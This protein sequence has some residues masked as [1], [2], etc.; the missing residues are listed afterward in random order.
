MTTQA[1]AKAILRHREEMG[2]EERFTPHDL[3]RTLRTRLAE[4]GIDDVI[5]ERIL[6]HKLQGIMAIYNRHG[7]DNEKRHALEKW[8]NKLKQIIGIKESEIGKI[9]EMRK[10]HA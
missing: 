2:F 4:L 8:E 9:I 7:Y 10:R 1:L 5:A 6:G 3:R